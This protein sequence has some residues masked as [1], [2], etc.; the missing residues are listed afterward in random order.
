MFNLAPRRRPEVRCGRCAAEP[1]LVQE[2]LD[3]RSGSTV[4]LYN[5]QCGEQIW[6]T[7]SAM[8]R[9]ASDDQSAARGFHLAHILGWLV[10][11]LTR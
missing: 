11:L 2:M 9:N 4:R 10:E 6:T 5:C 1:R 3:P 8:T 7:T